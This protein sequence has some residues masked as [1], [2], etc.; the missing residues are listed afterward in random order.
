MRCK[1]NFSIRE[2]LFSLVVKLEEVSIYICISV[3]SVA[4]ILKAIG[5]TEELLVLLSL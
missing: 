2:S 3:V 5:E 1:E 4:V